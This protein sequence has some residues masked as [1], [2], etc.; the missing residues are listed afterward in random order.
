MSQVVSINPFRCKMW[1]LHNRL[2][3]LL[4]EDNCRA[5]IGSFSK[6]G[7][8]IA[9]LGRPL[10]GDPD[11]DIE[12]IYGARRLFVARQLNVQ[13]R[14]EVGEISDRAAIIAMD[15]ENRQ[16]QDV[17]P[18]E[19]GLSFARCLR[20]SFFESQ[21][22][23]A[24]ALKISQSQ[25]SRLLTLARLPS[26]V[27]SA[28][29]DPVEIR[30]AWGPDL[31]AAL[32]DS[33]R[34]EVTISRAR[35]LASVSPRLPAVDVYQ[36]LVATSVVGR[37]VRNRAH[38]EVVTDFDGAPLFRIRSQEKTIALLLPRARISQNTLNA[39]RDSIRQVLQHA[40]CRP[41]QSAPLER[42]QRRGRASATAKD[43]QLARERIG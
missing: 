36:Q 37:K 33:R 41:T 13:L 34:R 42:P 14:V 18:Y 26:V 3:H 21:E 12:L 16:R 28:F 9:V 8:L 29:N 23:L 27:V 19:R 1:E 43:E 10:R 30:E 35:S 20:A 25:V 22:D 40:N 2:E 39:V 11:H 6:H 31:T 24:R 5:E 15:I 38:D 17:S 7:Q 4:S 32:K